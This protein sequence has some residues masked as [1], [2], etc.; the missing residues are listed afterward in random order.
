MLI[1][2]CLSHSQEC[3]LHERKNFFPHF[4]HYISQRTRTV[5]RHTAG[6]W[7]IFTEWMNEWMQNMESQTHT[8]PNPNRHELGIGPRGHLALELTL[9]LAFSMVL[10]HLEFP[11]WQKLPFEMQM[12]SEFL[13]IP[14]VLYRGHPTWLPSSS[15]G[16]GFAGISS[17]RASEPQ[18]T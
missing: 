18:S 5:S 1:I 16:T 12:K 10:V 9:L 15:P 4:V 2:Y 13:L 7:W 17:R 14:D 11:Y 8:A 6:P 3:K